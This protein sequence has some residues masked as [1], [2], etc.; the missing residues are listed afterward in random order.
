MG[1]TL[2]MTRR[3]FLKGA[4]GLVIACGAGFGGATRLATT[5]TPNAKT[6]IGPLLAE[7]LTVMP[8]D[9]FEGG[10]DVY[11]GDKLAFQV[12]GAGA[13]LIRYADGAHTLDDI[14]ALGGCKHAADQAAMFFVTLGQA[15]YLQNRVEVKLVEA[16]L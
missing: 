6:A 9:V 10:A 7:G 3:E 5:L 8:R 14:I 12:N 4:A 2:I 15:G 13:A 11:I 1:V 16:R